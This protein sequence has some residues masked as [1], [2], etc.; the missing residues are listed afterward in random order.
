MKT[1]FIISTFLMLSLSLV[2]VEAGT[3]SSSSYNGI[4][5]K[6][7]YKVYIPNT[8]KKNSKSPV[9]IML[10]GCQQNAED[11]AKGTRI[12][13]WAEKNKFIALFPE[14]NSAFNSFRCWNWIIPGNNS[15]MGESQVIIQMLDT[16]LKDYNGDSERVFAAGMSAGGSMVSILGN[17]YPER[18]KALASHDGSQFY[19]SY[20]GLDFAEIVLNGASVP[21]VVSAK[22]GNSCSSSVPNRPTKMPIII[23]HGMKSPLMSPIHAFQVE[24]EFKTFNDYLDNGIKDNSYFLEK[25]VKNVP[26]T[27]M[28][29]YNLFTT[30]NVDHEI[31]IERYMIDDLTHG[32]SGGVK[33]MPYNDPKGPDASA[34]IFKFFKNYGL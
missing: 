19:S 33:D 28:Y 22:Y 2:K 23:F 34:F 15:R 1:A 5:G 10:H 6:R 30:T 24:T 7:N 16:V 8:L 3:W 14:Q 29:G 11:F 27:D 18:F 13:K 17:C 21:A 25:D 26:A 4:Y 31:L 20:L 12:E 9:V 32:W